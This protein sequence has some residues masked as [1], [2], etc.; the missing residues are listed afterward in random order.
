[1]LPLAGRFQQK[2]INYNWI[3]IILPLLF[4]RKWTANKG[5]VGNK[6]ILTALPIRWIYNFS[7]A[8][9]CAR[10]LV[11]FCGPDKIIKSC[12]K[13]EIMPPVWF[14]I[15][16]YPISPRSNAGEL[17]WVK[18]Q[19]QF[20]KAISSKVFSVCIFVLYFWRKV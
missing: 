9:G 13:F 17:Y 11:I 3:S 12:Y 1:M 20:R 18:I 4:G 16:K 2:N 19:N 5:G 15:G 14:Y 6:S 10:R 8:T 7:E